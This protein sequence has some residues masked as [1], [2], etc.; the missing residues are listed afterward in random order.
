[1]TTPL[2]LNQTKAAE[3]LGIGV[4][5]FRQICKAGDGPKVWNPNDGRPMYAVAV[6]E[7]WAAHRDDR[8]DEV[9]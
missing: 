3:H 6:L 1:V 4:R 5:R 7:E 8:S 9:A 2:L